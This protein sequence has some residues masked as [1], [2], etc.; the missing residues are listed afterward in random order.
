MTQLTDSTQVAENLRA[1]LRMVLARFTELVREDQA[2]A[3]FSH[4]REFTMHFL[5]TDLELEFCLRFDHG[6]VSGELSAPASPPDLTLKMKA[7][8]LDGMLTGRT[9]ATRAAMTGKIAF[10]G[11][12]RK[13]MSMQKVQK[14]L[15][16]LY[17]QAR[18]EVGDP[19]DLI[20]AQELVSPSAPTAVVAAEP[21]VIHALVGDERDEIIPVL[22]ELY[23]AGLITATGGNISVRAEKDPQTAWITPS[24]IFKG[25]LRA[26]MLVR[27]DMQGETLDEEALSASS[28]RLVHC[29]VYR[30][31]P[32]VGAVV[33]THAP[34]TTVLMLAGLPFQ[35]ISTEAAFISEIPVV[36]F[37]MPGT[38]KLGDAVAETIGDG[39][40]VFMQNHGLVVAGSSL[41]RAAD[42]T[43][44]IETTAEKLIL[45]HLLGIDPPELPAEVVEEL[46]EYK[47]LMG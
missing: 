20:A 29:A 47:S 1:N 7:D 33:H 22:N 10:S 32:D 21:A 6:D 9:N 30:A 46:R 40:A 37:I 2:L 23:S 12:T 25:D 13:A 35:P 11:D 17:S 38:Q 28:E 42:L 4:N 34:N 19:G 5:V 45:L 16:R 15:T 26:E 36:P 18:E 41:R 3:D 8:I 43:E 44:I 24:Q 14:D 31:R 27:I 39:V